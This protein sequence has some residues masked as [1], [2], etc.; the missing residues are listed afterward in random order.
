MV[1][2]QIKVVDA[3]VL[4][5]FHF[6]HGKDHENEGSK[7]HFWKNQGGD[8]SAWKGIHKFPQ[9]VIIHIFSLYG[10]DVCMSVCLYCMSVCLYNCLSICLYVSMSLY[11]YISMSLCLYVFMSVYLYV[12]MSVCLYVCMF[13]CLYVCIY[14]CMYVCMFVSL[15]IYIYI[16]F[17]EIDIYN[18]K[19]SKYNIYIYFFLFI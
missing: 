6:S 16:L 10:H 8:G 7:R 13:V 5:I 4:C 9:F 18:K 2:N 17:A 15:Y 12:C 3:R 14:V 19:Y 11:L 1:D